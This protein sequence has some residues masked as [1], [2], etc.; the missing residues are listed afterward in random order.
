MARY[1]TESGLTIN[2]RGVRGEHRRNENVSAEKELLIDRE[3][4]RFVW[5]LEEER[6]DG[7]AAVHGRVREQGVLEGGESVESIDSRLWRRTQ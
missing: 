3:E 1:E 2:R 6:A 5:E 4:L 7:R